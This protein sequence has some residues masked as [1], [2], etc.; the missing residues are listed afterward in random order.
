MRRKTSV[1]SEVKGLNS[2]PLTPYPLPP[3][4]YNPTQHI[5]LMIPQHC[6]GLR[7]DQ[8]LQRLL[9]ECSRSRLQNW[10]RA[11]QVWQNDLPAVAKQKVRGG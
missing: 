1:R 3:A 4:D 9:P 7:L 8:A 10:I 6:A 11:R 2:L 5:E